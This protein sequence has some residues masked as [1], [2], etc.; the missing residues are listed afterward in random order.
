HPL[1][2]PSDVVP[3]AVQEYL[4]FFD[5]G[6]S[7]KKARPELRTEWRRVVGIPIDRRI[8]L[9]WF[10]LKLKRSMMGITRVK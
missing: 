5:M 8:E 7:L 10:V 1:S 3:E 9:R 2:Y 4:S 6:Q